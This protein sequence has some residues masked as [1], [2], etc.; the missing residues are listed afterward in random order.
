MLLVDQ[1]NGHLEAGSLGEN[2]VAGDDYINK[3]I[4]PCGECETKGRSVARGLKFVFVCQCHGNVSR[5][6][7]QLCILLCNVYIT[8]VTF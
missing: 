1:P 3:N 6:S 2:I 4:F 7:Y 8:G 5:I